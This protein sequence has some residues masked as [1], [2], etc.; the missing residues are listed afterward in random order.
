METIKASSLV[1]CRRCSKHGLAWAKSARTQKW[2]LCGVTPAWSE[3]VSFG[4]EGQV[5]RNHTPAG[6]YAAQ[7]YRPHSCKRWQAGQEAPEAIRPQDRR[8][9]AK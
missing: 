3:A 1:T 5:H 7:P 6:T 8:A 2:Y 9:S 4:P